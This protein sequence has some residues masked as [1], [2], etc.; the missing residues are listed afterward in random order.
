MSL[1]W[2]EMRKRLSLK[3]KRVNEDISKS[4][5]SRR[6]YASW[7]QDIV[8]VFKSLFNLLDLRNDSLEALC[9]TY[10]YLSS[11]DSI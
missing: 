8:Q 10:K 3:E 5:T 6:L 9:C 7:D 4:D 11:R 2:N 1:N